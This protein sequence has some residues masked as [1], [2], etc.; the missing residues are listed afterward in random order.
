MRPTMP[1]APRRAVQI[2]FALRF[3]FGDVDADGAIRLDDVA[4]GRAELGDVLAQTFDFDDH[5]GGDL[6]VGAAREA[7]ALSASNWVISMHWGTMPE[8]IIWETAAAASSTA[9]NWATRV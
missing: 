4:H 1:A 5:A 3:V 7:G 6:R 2:G 9:P 8:A